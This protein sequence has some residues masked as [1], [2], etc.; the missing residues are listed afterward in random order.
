MIVL[1]DVLVGDGGFGVGRLFAELDPARFDKLL[2]HQ[3]PGLGLVQ[4]RFTG[5]QAA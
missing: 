2:I 5:V 1:H 4:P 3:W